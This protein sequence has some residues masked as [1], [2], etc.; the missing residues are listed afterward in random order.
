MEKLDLEKEVTEITNNILQMINGEERDLEQESIYLQESIEMTNNLVG[1]LK[2]D[3]DELPDL[4]KRVGVT[5]A[6]GMVY[7][8]GLDEG[9]NIDVRILTA[10]TCLVLSFKCFEDEAEEFTDYILEGKE[11]EDSVCSYV[12]NEGAE[13]LFEYRAKDIEKIRHRVNEVIQKIRKAARQKESR[14]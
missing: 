1:I 11:I 10:E 4:E 9:I 7:A 14:K 13:L 12:L 6:F 3:P 5:M 2:W 8:K